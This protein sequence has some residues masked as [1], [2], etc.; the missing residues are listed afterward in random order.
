MMVPKWS[1]SEVRS[2]TQRK[3]PLSSPPLSPI[4]TF[5]PLIFE[6]RKFSFKR[7]ITH[8]HVVVVCST[9]S[10]HTWIGVAAAADPPPVET[11]NTCATS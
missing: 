10:T 2:S 11:R 4:F 5:V 1:D 8:N 6:I 7:T 3:C 9:P